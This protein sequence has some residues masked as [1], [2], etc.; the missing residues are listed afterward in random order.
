MTP[1]RRPWL[2]TAALSG[3]I[4]AVLGGAVVWIF[5]TSIYELS[6]N[7]QRPFLTGDPAP[8]PDYADP[9]AWAA[10]PGRMDSADLTPLAPA[11]GPAAP[12]AADVFFVHPTTAAE[13]DAWNLSWRTRPARRVD[14]I[15]LPNL[16]A[17]FNAGTRLYA[18]YYRQATQYTFRTRSDDSRMARR[19]AYDDVRRAF[20]H[21]L[22]R[23]NENRP[24]F[25]V[26][27]GQGAL[28]A[29]GLLQDLVIG[30]EAQERLIAAYIIGA[31]LP[32]DLFEDG[33]LAAL[34]PCRSPRDTGCVAAWAAF[35]WGASA[36]SLS[37][38]ALIWENGE[39]TAVEERPLLCVNP[40]SWRMDGAPVMQ[41]NNPGS[42]PVSARPGGRLPPLVARAAGAHC[43][44]GILR[45]DRP[46]DARLRRDLLPGRPHNLLDVALFY[47]SIRDNVRTRQAAFFEDR[48]RR[49]GAS[50]RGE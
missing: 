41:E 12:P 28:H 47:A 37:D 42:L 38:R 33:P 39:L 44:D 13:D 2:K 50:G 16:A 9:Q 32:A 6:I 18:P 34:P 27:T 5:W 7:P 23:L 4:L 30:T 22:T 20:R 10:F 40:L 11:M 36:R 29:A 48:K 14:R 15:A 26:G 49:P 45:V 31:A 8:A 43:T 24:F 19:F 17:A 25:L 3:A 21:F 35:P 1:A 46:S